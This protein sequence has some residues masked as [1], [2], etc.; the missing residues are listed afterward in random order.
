MLLLAATSRGLCAGQGQAGEGVKEE[1]EGSPVG[2]KHEEGTWTGWG[3]AMG[4][5][6][7]VRK[8]LSPSTS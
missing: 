2:R 6:R 4:V 5:E 1:E 8:G 7:T 3:R